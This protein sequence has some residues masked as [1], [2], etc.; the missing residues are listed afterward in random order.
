MINVFDILG[1]K[2]ITVLEQD[3]SPGKHRVSWN[4]KDT[5]GKQ[6]SSGVYL[7]SIKTNEVNATSKMIL[8]R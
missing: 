3:L 8:V 2:I 5:F 1:H 7:Y 4:G 6:V